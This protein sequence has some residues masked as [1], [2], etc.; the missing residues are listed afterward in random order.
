MGAVEEI[1]CVVCASVTGGNCDDGCVLVPTLCKHDLR[2]GD[3]LVL[4][5]TRVRRVRW[6]GIS[7]ELLMCGRGVRIFCYCLL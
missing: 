3:L 5:W 6:G 1:M 4:S 7:S 2:K